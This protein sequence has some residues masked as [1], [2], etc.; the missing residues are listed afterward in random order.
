MRFCALNVA[1]YGR[2]R[3]WVLTERPTRAVERAPDYFHIG[4]NALEWDGSGLTVTVAET[5]S[6]LPRR[7]VGRIRVLPEA[8]VDGAV[9]LNPAGGHVWQ[10]LAPCARIEVELEEPFLSWSGRGYT[11]INHGDEPLENGFVRWDW[12]RAALPDGTSAVVYDARLR[13]GADRCLA[14]RFDPAAGIAEMPTAAAQDLPATRWWRVARRLR[15]DSPARVA[16]TL[17][18]TPFYARS[19]VEAELAGQRATAVHESLS[20]DR[21]RSRWVQALLPFRMRRLSTIRSV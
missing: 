2:T 5:C 21:F 17:E 19:L 7:V 12:A 4:P 11:D 6:P 1:L 20:L 3:R 13:D 16:R 9:V 8:L 14:L 15:A 10:P 18:D